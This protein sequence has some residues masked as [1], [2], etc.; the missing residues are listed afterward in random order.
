MASISTIFLFMVPLDGRFSWGAPPVIEV[1]YECLPLLASLLSPLVPTS[2]VLEGDFPLGDS[3]LYLFPPFDVLGQLTSFDQ[4]FHGIL[5]MDTIVNVVVVPLMKASKLRFISL[6]R[7][8]N[9]KRGY[10]SPS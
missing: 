3:S 5:Y 4:S 2:A 9:R 6:G 1:I 7:L 10:D 8:S